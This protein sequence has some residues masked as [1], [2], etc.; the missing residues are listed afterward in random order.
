MRG[1]LYIFTLG[2]TP[3]KLPLVSEEMRVYNIC[4]A[5]KN[6]RDRNVWGL[7]NLWVCGR[8]ISK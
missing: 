7:A 4:C 3:A 1:I 8:S 5:D 6:R 2:C